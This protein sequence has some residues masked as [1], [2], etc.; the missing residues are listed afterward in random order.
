MSIPQQQQQ[1]P[2][3]PEVVGGKRTCAVMF[4]GKSVA[5]HT[6]TDDGKHRLFFHL[7]TLTPS[8]SLTA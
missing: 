4:C 1:Q 2:H 6:R 8:S 7:V 5:S 3:Q